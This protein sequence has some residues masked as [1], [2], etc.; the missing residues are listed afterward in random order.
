MDFLITEGA[1]G[2]YIS[3]CRDAEF[4]PAHPEIMIC[5]GYSP[6]EYHVQ[7]IK[8][9]NSSVLNTFTYKLDTRWNDKKNGPSF[10]FYGINGGYS[11]GSTWGGGVADQQLLPFIYYSS[12]KNCI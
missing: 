6:G 3:P 1:P 4:D 2:G 12:L 9:S 5:F 10:S 11:R 7:A 8:R